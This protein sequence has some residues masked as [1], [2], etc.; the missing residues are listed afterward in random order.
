MSDAPAVCFVHEELGAPTRYRVHHHVEQARLAGLHAEAVPLHAVGSR[1]DLRGVD[2][3][4]L[5]RL[6]LTRQ[7]LPLITA[8]R[9]R[10]IPI[11]YDSDDLVWDPRIRRYEDLDAHHPPAAVR[12]LLAE[13][14][15]ARWLMALADALVLSTPFLAEVAAAR[16]R[17]P[18]HV[19]PNALS[20]KVLRASA[21]ARGSRLRPGDSVTIA[22]FSGTRHV[23]DN[24]LASIGAAL[25]ATLDTHPRARLLLVGEVALPAPLAAPAYASRVERRPAVPWREL[26]FLLARADINLAPLVAN[27]QRR[28]KSAVKFLEAAAVAVPTVA[29]RLEPY[30]YDIIDGVTGR[31]A[32]GSD[33]WTR[34][35]DD[36]VRSEDLRMQL[37]DA[38]LQQAL[39]HHTPEFRAPAFRHTIERILSA[40]RCHASQ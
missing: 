12:Y 19:H 37:G 34:A 3:L 14:R 30:M 17:K 33:S 29:S 20:H 15:R 9:L 18:A 10:R 25:R 8:A 35:L 5:H 36:L 28:A 39:E 6:R 38:A 4:Y 11:V 7:T 16:F 22:Y 1:P 32:D 23:H 26:P 13:V 21:S 40:G 31:L 2:L 24:D 27:P